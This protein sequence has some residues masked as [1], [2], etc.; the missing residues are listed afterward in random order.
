MN[1]RVYF[2]KTDDCAEIAVTDDGVLQYFYRLDGEFYT[3]RIYVGK[4]KFVKKQVGVFVDI[5]LAKDGL[6]SYRESIKPGDFLLVQ[7]TKEP[8]ETKGCALTEKITLPGRYAVLNDVGEYKFSH[9][10]PEEKKIELFGAPRRENIGFIFRSL[11][12]NA[13][14]E[15]VFAE[16]ALLMEKYDSVLRAGK[17]IGKITC[18]YQDNAE[19]VAKRFAPSD[20]CFIQGFEE[21]KEQTARL[22][23]RKVNV[24]GVELV[25]DKTEAMTVVD[26]NVHTFGQGYADEESAAL[27]ANFIAVKELTRQLRLR[28]I[29]GIIMMD[30]ISMKKKENVEKLRDRLLEE[31][32]NDNVR[33]SVELVESIG[34]FAIVRKQRYASL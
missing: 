26:V 32:K 5:G 4:V 12:G 11:A 22:S 31:L 16:C 13:S 23:D 33:T 8:T 21:I 18:V 19:D 30:F 9:K 10:I 7:V 2:R 29:G 14:S 1:R 15:A 6:L 3:S 34:M 25:F 24:E 27:Q 20:E 17:N 28:N